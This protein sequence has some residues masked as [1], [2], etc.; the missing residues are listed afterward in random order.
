MAPGLGPIA[1]PIQVVVLTCGPQDRAGDPTAGMHVV[2]LVAS[3]V[4]R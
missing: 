2:D 4:R 3:V 1:E